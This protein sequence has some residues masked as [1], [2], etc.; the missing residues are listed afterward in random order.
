M[1]RHFVLRSLLA[2]FV[3]LIFFGA[4]DPANVG[5]AIVPAP[6]NGASQNPSMS[7]NGRYVAFESWASNLVVN[8]GNRAPDVFVRDLAAGTTTRVSVDIGGGD[9]NAGSRQPSISGDGRFVAFTSSATDLVSEDHGLT[10][11]A[12][13]I[14]VRDMRVGVTTRV[15][16][17]LVGGR[18]SRSSSDPSI[19]ADGKRV[20]FQSF[21]NNLVLGDGNGQSDIFVRDTRKGTTIRV[22]VDTAGGDPDPVPSVALSRFPSLSAD[23]NHVAFASEAPDL[24][25]GDRNGALDIFVRNLG[26]GTTTRASV[27]TEGGD[28]DNASDAPSIS[29]NGRYVAFSSYAL[30]L[31]SAPSVPA[32]STGVYV[33]DL[34]AAT[35]TEV[36]L[37]AVPSL[38]PNGRFVAFESLAALVPEDNNSEQ[39]IFVHDL[40]TGETVR[41]SVD[42]NGGDPDAVSGDPSIDAYGRAV[43]FTSTAGD[44]VPNDGINDFEVF[45]RDLTR[46]TTK[47]ATA[48]FG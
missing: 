22:S 18:P 17:N 28:P 9:A 10:P 35:T 19:S 20:A 42:V 2:A 30:D 26:A 32:G 36:A 13:S 6:P 44:L 16:V 48:V 21:A 29:R 15:S 40:Q 33:R 7:A 27:D 3:V 39:D 1:Q 43:A 8:D 12:S 31:V 24:V 23:G 11:A 38:S 37:G 46:A 47:R 45:V 34:R 25:S 14:F 4:A 41:A 5:A